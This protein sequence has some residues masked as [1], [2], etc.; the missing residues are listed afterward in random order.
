MTASVAADAAEA[1]GVRLE[2]LRAGDGDNLFLIPG[3]EGDIA[4]LIPMVSAMT[5]PQR[6]YGLMPVLPDAIGLPAAAAQVL[7]AIRG[8]QP[9]GPYQIGGYSFGALLAFEV[10]QQLRLDG[11]SVGTLFL[12]DGMYDER[13]W[14][15]GIWVRALIRRT[16]WQLGRIVRL[17]PLAALSELRLRGTRLLRRLL[18]RT[19]SASASDSLPDVANAETLS[20][21]HAYKAMAA[22]RPRTYPGT[23]TLIATLRDRHFGCDVA[24]LWRGLADRL[25]VQRVDGDHLTV[26]RERAATAAVADVIDHGLAAAR[27]G[28]P[29]VRPMP[30]FERPMILT[31]MRWFAAARLAH[32]LIEAGFAVS[33]CRPRGHVLGVLDGLTVDAPL[34]RMWR[35]RSL[36]AAIRRAR[37][38]VILPDDERALALLRRLHGDVRPTDPELAALIERSLGDCTQWTSITSRAGLAAAASQLGVTT[39][40]TAIVD[41]RRQLAEWP[42]PYALKTDGSWGG[43]GVAFVREPSQAGEAWRS[44]ANP[45]SLPRAVKRM[46]VNLET[47]P[48][49]AWVRRVRP[50]VNAQRFVEGREGIVTAAC[51][52]GKVTALVC[53][54]VVEASE[55]RGPA[56]AVRVVDHPQM[57]A[58]A[59]VL[60]E[61]FGLTGFCGFDFMITESGEA[62]LLEVNARVTPTCHLLVEGVPPAGRA[63]ALFPPSASASAAGVDVDVPGRVPALVAC[64]RSLTARRDRGSA[65]LLRRLHLTR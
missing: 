60:A 40:A 9:T 55:P 44:V 8:V 27:P 62:Y 36:I 54:E 63:F 3:I 23:M 61:R 14:P 22:Y 37:P 57:A 12:I 17:R 19:S 58:A 7:T 6:V 47:G 56:A 29:G 51:F 43:R 31:T 53:L 45:P 1:E 21:L 18:R 52:E 25:V 15:R 65:R 48:F 5:G 30:G 2:V 4:E 42:V 59:R 49:G 24:R 38:D 28:W 13:F 11:E 64:G 32:A 10:A 26:M 20:A 50:V 33:A 34:N 35:R 39:P 16:G 41:D 46:V